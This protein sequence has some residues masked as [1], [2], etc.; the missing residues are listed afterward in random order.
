MNPT[1]IRVARRI[2]VYM[3]EAAETGLPLQYFQGL[4]MALAVCFEEMTGTPAGPYKP[5]ELME[6]AKNLPAEPYPKVSLQ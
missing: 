4:G 3:L 2:V 1:S 6:W 5:R